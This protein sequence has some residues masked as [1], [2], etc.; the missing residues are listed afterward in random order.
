MKCSRVG[1]HVRELAHV[2]LNAHSVQVIIDRSGTEFHGIQVDGEGRDLGV[3]LRCAK[4]IIIVGIE[5]IFQ[6][7]KV[8]SISH[9]DEAPSYFLDY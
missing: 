2:I 7:L 1:S 5:L 4:L 6:M 9:V 3:H 8:H